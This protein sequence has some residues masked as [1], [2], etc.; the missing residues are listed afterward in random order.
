MITRSRGRD[1]EHIPVAAF[2]GL[3]QGVVVRVDGDRSVVETDVPTVSFQATGPLVVFGVLQVF[4]E[5][6]LLPHIFAQTAAD[7]AEEVIPH[8]DIDVALAAKEKE[9]LGK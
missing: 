4:A 5:A 3:L 2:I 1:R 9:I 6:A 7:H 8:P